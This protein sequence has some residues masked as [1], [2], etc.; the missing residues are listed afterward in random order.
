MVFYSY[1]FVS[2]RLTSVANFVK[3]M[4][5]VFNSLLKIVFSILFRFNKIIIHLKIWYFMHFLRNFSRFIWCLINIRIFY[6]TF[7]FYIFLTVCEKI[8]YVKWT[9]ANIKYFFS[10]HIFTNILKLRII[11]WIQSSELSRAFLVTLIE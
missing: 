7:A 9:N 10:F 4:N 2:L 11:I 1:I 3:L 5:R 8:I 6:L